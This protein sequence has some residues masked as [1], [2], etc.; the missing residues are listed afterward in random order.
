MAAPPGITMPA[1]VFGEAKPENDADA[2]PRRPVLFHAHAHSQGPLRVVA[3]DLRS[4]A[5]HCSLDL[6][7]LQDL[8]DDVGIGGSCSDL[9]DYLYSSLS[10]GQVRIRF[11]VD[12]GPGTATAKLVATKAKGLPLITLS[13]HPVAASELEDAIADFSIALYAS[14][15]TTQE[16]ASREQERLSQLMDSLASEREKNEVMQ[17][18]LEALSFLDKRKA[19]KQKLVTDQVPSVSGAPPVSDQVI[20]PVQQQTSVASPSK[21]PPA[22]AVKRVAPVPRRARV[23]GALLQ[24]TEENDDY[25]S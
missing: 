3:T 20:V 22:K 21:V 23:R 12:Q 16:H 9:L 14:Y 19:T 15:K 5:W 13:L 18:Q 7:D 24:D 11:P 4:L 6:D 25:D 1:A 8:Q 17:K 2:L 10:S